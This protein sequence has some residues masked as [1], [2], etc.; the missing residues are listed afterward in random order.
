MSNE[1]IRWQQRFHNFEK[2]FQQFAKAVQVEEPSDLERAG[3]IQFY[4]FTFEL[5]WKTLKD[6]LK[7]A[8][9]LIKSPR[10]TIKQAF[11]N[12][13]LQ[14]GHLWLSML[15]KR[16]DLAHAYKEEIAAEA[17]K[18]IKNE[19]FTAIQQVYTWLKNQINSLD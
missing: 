6:Y 10:E 16:N 3:I 8:G 14:D 5:A 13:Y 12:G 7:E 4:E 2:A 19:Y 9:Y 11:Q 18:H 15:E 17:L 1:D